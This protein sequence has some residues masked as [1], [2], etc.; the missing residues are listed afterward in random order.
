MDYFAGPLSKLEE[1][2]TCF[3]VTDGAARA[4]R[5][6]TIEFKPASGGYNARI[7]SHQGLRRATEA[8]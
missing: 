6:M 3:V 7:R 2:E 1:L 4:V 5:A 8:D